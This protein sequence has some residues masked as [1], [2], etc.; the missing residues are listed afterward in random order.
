MFSPNLIPELSYFIQ[1]LKFAIVAD[2]KVYGQ[3]AECTNLVLLWT[4]T[5][6]AV[7]R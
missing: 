4:S 5:V 2:L 1:G 7:L 6:S 3:G